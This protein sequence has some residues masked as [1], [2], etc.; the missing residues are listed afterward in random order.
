MKYYIY[1]IEN[2]VN[3]KKYIGLTNNI[4]RRRGRHFTDLKRGA[5]D[6]HHLQKE[7]DIYGKEAF[8]FTVEFEGDAEPDEISA[9][10]VEYIA[11]Y[12]SYRNGYNQNEGGNFGPSNGG[13]TLTHSDILNI[14]SAL[15]F[16]SRPGQ[17]L[18]DIFG[19]SRTTI[20]RIK[21]GVNHNQYKEE[22]DRLPLE[23]RQEIY[24]I[25][26][27]SSNFYEKK[28]NTTIIQ[29]KR[30]LTKDQVFMIFYNDEYKCMPIKHLMYKLGLKSSNTIYCILQ[31]R[32]Y[33]DFALEYSRLSPED[34]KYIASLLSN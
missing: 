26:C 13:T 31:G 19:V 27:D 24:R 30:Q 23:E 20:S 1:K 32:S 15:E 34:K 8:V 25:F 28:V 5:H 17:I 7:Y 6:N 12:D 33:K 10:E 2:T 11:R 9:L 14:L 3:H 22:Y 4:A 29:S 21:Q 18:A 16:M